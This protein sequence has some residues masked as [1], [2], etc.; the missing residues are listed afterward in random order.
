VSGDLLRLTAYIGERARSGDRFTADALLD[1]YGS[2]SVA[3]SVV[4]RGIAGFGPRHDLRSDVTLTGSEDPP[5]AVTAVDTAATIRALASRAADLVPRGLVT[6]EAVRSA[7]GP[8]PSGQPVTV[9]VFVRRG[10]RIAGVLAYQAVG[11]VLR[12]HGFSAATAYLGVDGTA[13]GHRRRAAFFSRNVAVPAVVVAVGSGARAV[14]ALEEVQATPGV[15]M[16][17][18]E[19]VELR[20]VDGTVL[21]PAPAA[22]GA[23]RHQ[24]LTVQ[25]CESALHDGVPVHR[26]L[27][28]RLREVHRSAGVTVVRGVWG[29]QGDAAP[30]SDSLFRL[31]RRVPVTTTVVDTP[32]RIAAGLAMV[33]ALTAQHGVV[34]VAPVEAAL[35]IDGGVR[36]GGL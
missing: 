14:A 8:A 2:A 17:T 15:E 11:E 9:T 32:E 5:I 30:L 29:F 31:G 19:A 4:V 20:K 26:A 36:R 18:V 23:D 10:Q 25:T 21:A 28:A 12:R 7:D 35:S 16:L 27:V 33:E 6:L 13:G 1:L 3:H 22:D 34:T 24:R